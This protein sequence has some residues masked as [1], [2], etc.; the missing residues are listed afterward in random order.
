MARTLPAWNPKTRNEIGSSSFMSLYQQRPA[1]P[2]EGV[3]FRREWWRTY[4]EQPT[5]TRV[6]QSWD[7]GFKSG[8]DNDFSVCTTWGVNAAGYFLLGLAWQRSNSPN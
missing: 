7:T 5:C 1:A 4:R 6:I 2:A 8:P 3:I